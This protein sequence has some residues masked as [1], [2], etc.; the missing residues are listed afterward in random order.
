MKIVQLEY[1]CA[2]ARLHSITQAAAELYVTQPAVSSAIKELEKEFNVRLF[3]RSKNHLTLTKEGE[4]F[5]QKAQKLL[6]EY[7][8][9]LNQLHD[10]GRT[11][12][13]VKI[14]IP[15]LLSTIFFPEMIN[16]FH[17]EYPD[18]PFELF[19]YGS[20]RAANLVHEGILDAALVNMHFY[21]ID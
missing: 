3:N 20:I 18:I 8:Q 2:V 10:I 1:F 9:T 14:G 16:D 5:Y 19:E 6:A 12:S 13:A 15:P 21:E 4:L 11:I 17:R 7:K